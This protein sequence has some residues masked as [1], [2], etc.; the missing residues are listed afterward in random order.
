MTDQPRKRRKKNPNGLTELRQRKVE[1]AVL[2]YGR[3]WVALQEA[4]ANK[5]LTQTEAI[6]LMEKLGL[7]AFTAESH[8]DTGS[9][10]VTV[11]IVRGERVKIDWD[12]FKKKIGATTWKKI[13]KDVPDQGLVDQAIVDGLFTVEDLAECSSTVPNSPYLK[14]SVKGVL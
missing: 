10:S 13:T 4:T 3:A 8:A 14:T 2:E 12:K 11:S 6:E 1:E 5:G 7:K 9:G